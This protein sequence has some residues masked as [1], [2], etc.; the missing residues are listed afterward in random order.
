MSND[1]V[2]LNSSPFSLDTGLDEIAPLKPSI[3]QFL[4]PSTSDLHG[5]EP[6]Q[7]FDGTTNE[8]YDSLVVVPLRVMTNRVLYPPGAEIKAGVK[9]LC[10][11][12]NGRTPSRFIEHPQSQ[13]CVNCKFAEWV[14]GKPSACSVNLKLLC[15]VK[16]REAPRYIVAAGTSVSPLRAILRRI[17][18]DIQAQNLKGN[19]VR[20]YDYFFEVSSEK[21]RNYF[22]MKF[23][24]VQRVRDLGE[25]SSSYAKYV[26]S[27]SQSEQQPAS[28]GDVV[29]AEIVNEI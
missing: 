21:R 18:E 24:K 4:Q 25:F 12:D 8:L 23:D 10:R 14:D 2:T 6:G 3:L 5:G 27:A 20:L 16:D 11:S 15:L 26:A 17:N 13:S 7:F 1:L 22:V 9:P 28:G 19:P 29:D